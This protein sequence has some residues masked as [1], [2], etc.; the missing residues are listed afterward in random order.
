MKR[1]HAV[2]DLKY[3]D[4]ALKKPKV[5]YIPGDHIF[6]QD[7]DPNTDTPFTIVS[8]SGK[9]LSHENDA[10]I[11]K[12]MS[13]LVYA[14]EESQTW[15]FSPLDPTARNPKLIAG[16]LNLKSGDG[17][18][19]QIRGVVTVSKHGVYRFYRFS[20]EA[21][22]RSI[23]ATSRIPKEEI[24]VCCNRISDTNMKD[25]RAEIVVISDTLYY[26]PE[27]CE[28]R[29]KWVAGR[30]AAK[31]NHTTVPRYVYYG[32]PDYET[33]IHI[34]PPASIAQPEVP[35]PEQPILEPDA[36]D[37]KKAIIAQKLLLL[38]ETEDPA[39]VYKVIGEALFK[40]LHK[41]SS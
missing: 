33:T 41:N 36:D 6:F 24:L 13:K 28:I 9:V 4:K 15:V 16:K 8:T 27:A 38:F 37:V 40:G 14:F 22:W 29:L 30:L 25:S 34:N 11:I 26:D 19:S 31:G 23:K 2:L 10:E 20:P 21:E 35:E 3:V 17:E 39:H 32:D 12:D 5:T 7:Q 18:I 1:T